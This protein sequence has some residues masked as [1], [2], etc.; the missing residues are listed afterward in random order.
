MKNQFISE[1]LDNII[2]EILEFIEVKIFD[3]LM[4]SEFSSNV[5]LVT[6]LAHY[7]NFRAISLDVIIELSSGHV[8]ELFSIADIT[9]KFRAAKLSMSLK[10]SKSLPDNLVFSI[11]CV[12]SMWK[13]TEINTV[14]QNFVNF[15][16]EITSSLTVGAANV[17]VWS[18]T[19]DSTL[20]LSGKFLIHS[21]FFST[22]IS[23]WGDSGVVFFLVESWIHLGFMFEIELLTLLK[24]ELTVFA[25]EFVA[26]FALQWLIRKLETDNALDFLNHLSLK[27][28]LN[29]VHLDIKRRNWFWSHHF[30]DG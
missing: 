27:F 8:L 22:A 18:L 30:F 6:N 25:E 14:S 29:L 11:G 7:L 17:I 5:L 20:V 24:L 1:V 3:T 23:T 16:H 13:L 10:F 9:T 2:A 4:V 15:L 19:A 21:L 28:V 26:L 12:A